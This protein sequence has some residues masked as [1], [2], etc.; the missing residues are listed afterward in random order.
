[1]RHDVRSDLL[2]PDFALLIESLGIEHREKLRPE[3]KGGGENADDL[4]GVAGAT[5][6]IEAAG[7]LFHKNV[8]MVEP[9]LERA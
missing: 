2:A 4:D 9:V 3:T 1:M 8:G 7:T 5:S 6:L